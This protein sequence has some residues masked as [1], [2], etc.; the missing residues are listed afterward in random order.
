[1][2]IGLSGSNIATYA[3]PEPAL[4]MALA[5]EA[6]GVESLWT[7]EHIVVPAGYESRYPYSPTG[8]MGM[9]P[10][11]PL[12]D[13]LSWLTFVSAVTDRI[14]LGTGILILPEHNPVL[15]AKRAAT[16]DRL[17]RGRLVLGIGVGWMKEEFDA[18]GVPWERRGARTNEYIDAM[19]KLWIE[20]EPSFDGEFVSYDRAVCVPKPARAGGVEIVVGGH[21]P[22]AARRAGNRGDGFFPTAT[23]LPHLAEL[24][25]TMRQAAGEAGRDPDGIEITAMGAGLEPEHLEPLLEAG[26]SRL[27]VPIPTYSPRKIEEKFGVLA[28]QIARLPEARR[29]AD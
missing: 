18:L 14:K 27:V 15:L 21:S 20:D 4:E 8:R 17:S 3:E 12:T 29:G 25:E 19:R 6:A 16:I 23:S 1:M 11:M 5:A 26:V 10:E 24:V 22:Q 13:P 2:K 9:G 7:Y 28:E